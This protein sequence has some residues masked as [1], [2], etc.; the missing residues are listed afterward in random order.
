MEKEN[1][2]HDAEPGV[3]ADAFLGIDEIP[4]SLTYGFAPGPITFFC[5]LALNSEDLEARQ[6]FYAQATPDQSKGRHAYNVGFLSRVVK[7]VDGLPGYEKVDGGIKEYFW[8][9]SEMSKKIAADA[10]DMYNK[11]VQPDEFFR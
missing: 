11:A 7:R 10:V 1:E 2:T 6:K 9:P 8:N 3:T 4:V 5:K